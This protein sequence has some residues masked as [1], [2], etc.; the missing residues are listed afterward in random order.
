MI[1]SEFLDFGVR[2]HRVRDHFPCVV[3][4]LSTI[5]FKEFLCWLQSGFQFLKKY[6]A[7]KVNE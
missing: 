6:F 2:K 1:V 7:C 4:I 3:I 5:P